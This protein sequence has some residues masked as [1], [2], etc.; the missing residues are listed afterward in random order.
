MGVEDINN[1]KDPEFS[2][3]FK[4]NFEPEKMPSED[5]SRRVMDRVMNEWISQSSY[6][7]PLVDRHNRWW[8]VPGI[9]ALFVI[10]FLFD[11]GQMATPEDQ[12]KWATNLVGA[13]EALYSWI[14]PIH[15]MII[16]A[17]MAVGLLLVFDR[18]L[19]KLS[20]I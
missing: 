20:N 2:Q 13:F 12:Y 16:G 8:I 1:I 15:L 9:L 17:S 4:N 7:K 5:F 3:W 11:V 6:Y 18:F 14:E 10:G 19:Q